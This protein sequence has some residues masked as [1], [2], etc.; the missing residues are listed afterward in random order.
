MI[1][2]NTDYVTGREV[3]ETLGLV[4][5]N[6]VRAAHLGRDIKAGFRGLTGGKVTEYVEMLTDSREEAINEMV[7][8]AE[9]M[10]ADAVIN[11]RFMTSSVMQSAAEVLVYGTAVKFK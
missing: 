10:G 9:S 7:E 5:G 1:L 2:V 3:E 4:R 8:K 6:T 11:V